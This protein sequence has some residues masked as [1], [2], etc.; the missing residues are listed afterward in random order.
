MGFCLFNNG[1]IGARYVQKRY[2][3]ERVLIVDWDVHHGNGTQEIFYEDASIF[4][5]STHQ[6]PL[7]P[8]TGS[9]EERG[10]YENILNVPIAANDES[11]ERV[12]EAFGEPLSRAME[13]FKPQFVMISAGFDAHERDPL[14]GFNLRDEDYE[15]L[16]KLVKKIAKE[17][18]KERLISV[19]EGGYDLLALSRAADQHV[20]ALI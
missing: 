2:G 16:T 3:I 10:R 9:R 7:Y 14:G 20:A 11:R 17:Y 4:Y 13:K 8:G 18:A 6:Y 19:L 15:E 1:A 12:L 5:F